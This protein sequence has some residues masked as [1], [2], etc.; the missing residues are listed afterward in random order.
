MPKKKKRC[1]HC[2][3]KLNPAQRLACACRCDELVC[4]QCREVHACPVERDVAPKIPDAV[5]AT[6]LIDKL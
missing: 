3:K 5:V 4:F 2:N 1:V 6:T